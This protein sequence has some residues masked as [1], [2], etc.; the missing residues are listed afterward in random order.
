MLFKIYL[1][2]TDIFVK[3]NKAV[4][5]MCNSIKVTLAFCT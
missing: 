4:A 3:Y 1:L 5:V 2:Q